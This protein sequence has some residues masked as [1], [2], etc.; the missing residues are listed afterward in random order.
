MAGEKR[1]KPVKQIAGIG[2]RYTNCSLRAALKRARTRHNRR[3]AATASAHPIAR[4][5]EASSKPP[6]LRG[7]TLRQLLLDRSAGADERSIF[8]RARSEL[9][10]RSRGRRRCRPE[11][12][13]EFQRHGADGAAHGLGYERRRLVQPP[14]LTAERNR[15][16]QR[17]ELEGRAA[18][19][20]QRL[21][22]RR[23]A[24]R[25][26][27]CSTATHI[28]WPSRN[29]SSASPRLHRRITT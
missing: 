29:R 24:T 17:R 10:R 23:S 1:G 2:L 27:S 21:R 25:G 8:C 18:R 7:L 19:A 13:A 12:R 6:T 9:G 15:P 14:L 26:S 5:S 28:T 20:A 4:G 16:L 3:S 22:H 11:P